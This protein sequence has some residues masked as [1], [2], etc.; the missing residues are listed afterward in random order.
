MMSVELDGRLAELSDGIIEA[1]DI[2]LLFHTITVVMR[3]EHTPT[4]AVI[5]V[6]FERVSA[7]SFVDSTGETE[8]PPASWNDVHLKAIYFDPNGHG[9][10]YHVGYP[11]YPSSS[12][13]EMLSS[14]NFILVLEHGTLLVE[15][16]CI[17]LEH[18]R[19]EVDYP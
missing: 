5:D 15:A 13:M 1:L 16:E 9:S 7:F 19:F 8:V 14:A 17:V 3:R 6:I 18:A 2:D 11:R 10:F 12:G 4:A